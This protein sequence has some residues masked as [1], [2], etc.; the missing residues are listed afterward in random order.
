MAAL[1][2][3]V[4]HLKAG[5]KSTNLMSKTLQDFVILYAKGKTNKI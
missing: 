3:P 1:E 4:H 5:D 2:S